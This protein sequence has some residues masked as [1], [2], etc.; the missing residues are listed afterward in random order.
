MLLD[1]EIK[2]FQPKNKNNI[3][4]NNV[5]NDK[6]VNKNNNVDNNEPSLLLF[7]YFTLCK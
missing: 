6:N 7:Y 1:N 3:N 5:N 4:N 2:K